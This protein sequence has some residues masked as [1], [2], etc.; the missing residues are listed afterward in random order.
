M[1]DFISTDF[2]TKPSVQI[3]SMGDLVTL[4]IYS[5]NGRDA[6]TETMTAEAAL[7]IGK[8]L[9]HAA[10]QIIGHRAISGQEAAS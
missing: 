9:T 7:K 4:G 2:G 10:H 8:A 3:T 1:S 5:Q 6:H